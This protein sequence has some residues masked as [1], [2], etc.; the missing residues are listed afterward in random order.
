MTD[1]T[2]EADTP[3]HPSATAP[4]H[5][6]RRALL[7]G[8]ALTGVAVPF[9]AACGGSGGASS[10][11]S[12][13]GTTDTTAGGSG[14]GGGATTVLATT[15]QVPE[16][17]GLILDQD[18]IVITQPV[19]GTFKDF[20]NICTHAQCPVSNVDNGTINCFCH[21]SMFSIEDGSV[22]GGPAT[23]PL[24]PKNVAVKGKNI[25]LA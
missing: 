8:A 7:R 21:G 25:T 12:G 19:A 11:A 15:S 17:G 20:S 9:L 14:G 6:S 16:G 1:E 4:V 2:F 24:P 3:E 5:P 13:A 22:V 23:S 10:G 18:G